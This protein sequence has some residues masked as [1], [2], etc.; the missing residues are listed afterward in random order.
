MPAFAVNMLTTPATRLADAR[1]NL[2][3]AA[4][5]G[6]RRH[7]LRRRS[8]WAVDSTN[9]FINAVAAACNNA[10]GGSRPRSLCSGRALSG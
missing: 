9:A 4:A 7:R 10:A 3:A 1:N 8:D 6:Q 2:G 5:K